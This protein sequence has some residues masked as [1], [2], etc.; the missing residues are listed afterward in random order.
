M[1]ITLSCRCSPYSFLGTGRVR[2]GESSRAFGG[3]RTSSLAGVRANV[4]NCGKHMRFRAKPYVGRRLRTLENLPGARIFARISALVSGRV[5][6]GCQLCPNGCITYSLLGNAR[7]FT[8]GCAPRRGG[9]FRTCLRGGLSLVRLPGGSRS[10]LH[11][12]VLAVCTGPTVGRL[13]TVTR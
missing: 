13:G 3:D 8:K 9:H 11:R 5:R 2:R 6:H 1:P 12:Q 4:F 7:A 10:F